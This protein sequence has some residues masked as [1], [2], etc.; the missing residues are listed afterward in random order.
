M[1]D[2][3]GLLNKTFKKSDLMR[4]IKI[5]EMSDAS[6]L[7]N[8][9]IKHFFQDLNKEEQDNLLEQL[10]KLNFI[11]NRNEFTYQSVSLLCQVYQS[12]T[13]DIKKYMVISIK[14]DKL[15]V[16]EPDKKPLGRLLRAL[17]D[18]GFYTSFLKYIEDNNFIRNSIA[19]Y[20]YYLS[21]EGKLVF[22]EGLLGKEEEKSISEFIEMTVDLNVLS[23][24]FILIFLDKFIKV[25]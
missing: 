17:K 19:H 7:L 3:N 18:K 14:F 8:I 11:A 13:E 24:A 12:Y 10:L 6:F 22:C 1:L 25:E 20:S 15:D 21:E 4:F 2:K 9:N 23:N 16:N 5:G